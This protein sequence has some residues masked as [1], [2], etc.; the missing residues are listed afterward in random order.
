MPVTE[1]RTRHH[2]TPVEE[3]SIVRPVIVTIISVAPVMEES[4]EI[5]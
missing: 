4:A 3:G 1:A 5:W 2:Q